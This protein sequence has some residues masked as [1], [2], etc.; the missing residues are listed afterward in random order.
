M[1]GR[2]AMT[3]NVVQRVALVAMMVPSVFL[4]PNHRPEV[5]GSF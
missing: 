2:T 5:K 3:S 1:F 4:I